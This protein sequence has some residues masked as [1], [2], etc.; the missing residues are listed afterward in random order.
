MNLAEIL[1]DAFLSALMLSVP[2]EAPRKAEPTPQQVRAA[3][4]YKSVLSMRAMQPPL[5]SASAAE[6]IHEP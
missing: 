5:A 4:Q 2:V 3:P 1:I 6:E